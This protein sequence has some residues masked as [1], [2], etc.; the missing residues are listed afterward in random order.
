[1]EELK[2]FYEIVND[3]MG[4][5][6]KWKQDHGGKII[7]SFCSYT[8]EEIIFAA[9]ALCFRIFGTG[10][11]HSMADAHLQAYSCSLVRGA[12][13]DA[14]SG[15]LNFLDG[16]VFPH[17][18]DS[19]QR[20]SDIWRIN[21]PLRLHADVVLPVKLDTQSA[22]DYMVDVFKTFR[23]QLEKHLCIK[24]TEEA[25]KKSV[26][27]YNRIR[28]CLERIYNIRRENPDAIAARDVNTLV[29]ASMMMDRNLLLDNLLQITQRLED[30]RD[31][32][33]SVRKRLIIS[34][35][36]C[37]M[38]DLF[39]VIEDSGGAVVW[40]DLCTG[41]RYFEGVIDTNGDVIESIARRYA[42]R[43]ICPAK[44]SG[45]L[46]RGEQLVQLAKENQADGIIFLLLKFCDPH[47]FDFPYIKAMLEKEGVPAMLLEVED[48]LTAGGR[49]KTR[50]EA[51]LE[52]LKPE[53]FMK[54]FQQTN[55]KIIVLG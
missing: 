19:I 25:L 45:L 26:E 7:G 16:V 4:Y 47:A 29:K 33:A 6:E 5:A 21:V 51:F 3:P 36:V 13:E 49:L 8:P 31:R 20:L 18:C 12:L 27:T 17:T 2:L 41:S 44:H 42:E 32:A 24:I 28:N 39:Q 54:I 22:R 10:A 48:Q 53:Y 37:N 35:G 34:G 1:M 43:C 46:S 38:P 40:D 23:K 55:L 9:D 30:K 50:L 52:M 11:K 14:L 15:R